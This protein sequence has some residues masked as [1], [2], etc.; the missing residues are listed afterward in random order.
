VVAIENLFVTCL[1]RS[2]RAAAEAEVCG[3]AAWR[4]LSRA[5]VLAS[6]RRCLAYGLRDVADDALHALLPELG[7]EGR[8][9]VLLC[10]AAGSERT[11][12][13]HRDGAFE[14]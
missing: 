2:V 9:L 8:L 7:Q 10:V 14:R 3:P 4:N 12:P 5:G 13:I 1:L 11:R 6:Y